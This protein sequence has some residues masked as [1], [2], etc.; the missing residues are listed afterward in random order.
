MALQKKKGE[1]NGFAERNGR[2][3]LARAAQ[4]GPAS[5][6]RRSGRRRASSAARGLGFGLCGGKVQEMVH[7][8]EKGEG[9]GFAERMGD[10]GLRAR[11]GV[12]R[13]RPGGVAVGGGLHWWRVVLVSVCGGARSGDDSWVGSSHKGNSA[14][15]SRSPS[16]PGESPPQSL[17]PFPFAASSQP[18]PS[19]RTLLPCHP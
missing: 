16:P 17:M 13:R 18:L 3:G 5:L 9:N 15:P 7:Q 6:R 19:L 10:G 2:W 1:G 4:N 12:V 8:R 11:R 14:L